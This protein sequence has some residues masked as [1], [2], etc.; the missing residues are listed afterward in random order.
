MSG[1]PQGQSI[2][3]L[4]RRLRDA[5]GAA[6]SRPDPVAAALNR[7]AGDE[8]LR[9]SEF[10][11]GHSGIYA[12]AVLATA[13]VNVL[14]LAGSLVV[15]NVYDRVLPNQAIE[16]LTALVIGACLA[17]I[18]E[19]T[20]RM[21]RASLIDAASREIDLRLASRIYA[22][23]VGAR[24]QGAA[25]STGVR[26]N[27][28]REFETL[29]DF[30][31]SATLTALGDLPFA[32]LFILIIAIVAGPLVWVPLAMIPVL[33]LIQL[34]LQKP[35]ARLTAESFRDTAQKNA[36]LVETLVGLETV[37]AQGAEPWARSLWDRSVAEHVRVGL[38]TR[39]LNALAQ[40]SVGLVQTAATMA[41]LVY[42]T[43][44]IGRGDITGGALMAAMTLIGRAVAP[45]AQGALMI[46]RIHQIRVAWA[47]LA[48]LA[49]APQE[50]PAD[51]DFVTPARPPASI[52]FEGVTFAY[53]RTR[54]P[55]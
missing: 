47:A 5:Y 42:G 55:P 16:T 2:D 10:F 31:T 12:Q 45:I 20:L 4:G 3:D 52:A 26:I 23:V 51:A 34:A 33:I 30:F 9:L 38:R 37:K 48:Q 7:R 54:R 8:R 27:T 14:A 53:G 15:M 50:R 11:Q 29:R 1:A 21:L 19:F 43:I 22:R 39:F 28:L 18:F 35:L 13:V 44:L 36:V 32:F 41:L 17:A 49:N 40:N 46:G 6:P 25:G 24:L